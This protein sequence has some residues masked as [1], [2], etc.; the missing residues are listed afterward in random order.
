MRSGKWKNANEKKRCGIDDRFCEFVIFCA[1]IVRQ[2][3]V[4]RASLCYFF[5]PSLLN[6]SSKISFGAAVARETV[7]WGWF[8]Y[9]RAGERGRASLFSVCQCALTVSSAVT[10]LKDRNE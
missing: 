9:L 7:F 8:W 1:V 2:T 6:L 4:S 5:H 3:I 10:A